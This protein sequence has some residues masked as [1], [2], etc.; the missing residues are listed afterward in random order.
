VN[1]NQELN[2]TTTDTQALPA[3]LLALMREAPLWSRAELT[4]RL[5]EEELAPAPV[6]AVPEAIDALI[7]Q[8]LAHR[9]N[10]E[11]VAL[12]WRGRRVAA[13]DAPGQDGALQVSGDASGPGVVEPVNDPDRFRGGGEGLPGRLEPISAGE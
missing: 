6:E 7:G 8:G 3:W 5:A 4:E 2:M 11:L 12:S 10:E 1:T 13:S 9:V